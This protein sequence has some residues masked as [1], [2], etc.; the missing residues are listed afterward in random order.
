MPAFC[1]ARHRHVAMRRYADERF[2]VARYALMMYADIAGDAAA[3][4]RHFLLR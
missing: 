3:A 2:D 4:E 1:H